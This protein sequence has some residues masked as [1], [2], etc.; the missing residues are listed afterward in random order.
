MA[1]AAYGGPRQISADARSDFAMQMHVS[2]VPFYRT[3]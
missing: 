3:V 2:D 1:W